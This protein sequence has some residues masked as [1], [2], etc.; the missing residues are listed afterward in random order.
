MTNREK[1]GNEFTS[2]MWW[3]IYMHTI[4][5][6]MT[7]AWQA[8]HYT[9]APP[10]FSHLCFNDQ[11]RLESELLNS[12]I[13]ETGC[14]KTK[15]HSLCTSWTQPYLYKDR[16]ILLE[17]VTTRFGSLHRSGKKE[18]LLPHL[19]LLQTFIPLLNMNPAVYSE[20][21]FCK[22]M[23]RPLATAIL[24]TACCYSCRSTCVCVGT[25]SLSVQ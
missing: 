8:A 24:M 16:K 15:V 3:G 1:I 10:P 11:W 25:F 21:A 12:V 6:G 14:L 23:H 7:W 9:V 18:L 5:H 17:R 13:C 2:Q 19:F 22:K 20:W 4:L